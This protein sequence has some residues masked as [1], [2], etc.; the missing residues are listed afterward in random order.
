MKKITLI[1]LSTLV[2]VACSRPHDVVLSSDV[3][4]WDAEIKVPMEKLTE[5][6]RKLFS[7]YF[8]RVKKGEIF[9]IKDIPPGITIG[10]A[11]ADQRK[12]MDE[13]NQRSARQEAFEANIAAET[14]AFRRKVSEV[15]KIKVLEKK[16]LPID[17]EAKRYAAEQILLLSF[18]NKTVKDIAGV[19]G[20][21]I[22]YDIFEKEVG[23]V[24]FA[25]DEGIKA[26]TTTTWLNKRKSSDF[27]AE[28]RELAALEEGRYRTQFIPE[29]VVFEDG[30]KLKLRPE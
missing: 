29:M 11:I 6:E 1:V 26:N 25:F 16:I 19:K 10:K 22:F 17:F 8:L 15:V 4:K 28:Y 14:A 12:W 21:L 30:T 9:G 13:L 23:R 18:E 27:P 24:V 3:M 20:T 2:L 5:E 7:G